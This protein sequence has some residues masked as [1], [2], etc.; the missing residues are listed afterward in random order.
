MYVC[1]FLELFLGHQGM[2]EY[3][4][5]PT[6]RIMASIIRRIIVPG[7]GSVKGEESLFFS[8]ILERVFI[9]YGSPGLGRTVGGGLGHGL[10]S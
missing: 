9:T 7:M 1:T 4:L 8:A 6:N 10:P 2:S 5:A 3:L